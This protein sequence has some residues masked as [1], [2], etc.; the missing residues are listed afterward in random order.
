MRIRR[1]LIALARA[2]AN[3]GVHGVNE[4]LAV[5]DVAGLGGAGEHGGD[6]VDQAVRHHHLDLDLGKEVHRVLTAPI[7]LRMTLLPA[8]AADLGDRHA[9]HAYASQGL[10][11]VVE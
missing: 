10:L 5:T 11:D 8:E 2:N 9:D 4:D 7:E 1:T 3:R 6:L